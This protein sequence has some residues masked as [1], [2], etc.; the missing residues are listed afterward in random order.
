VTGALKRLEDVREAM[1]QLG[2]ELASPNQGIDPN[3]VNR[4]ITERIDKAKTT[5]KP[6]NGVPAGN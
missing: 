3:E 5:I 1:K 4:K 6:G 2:R